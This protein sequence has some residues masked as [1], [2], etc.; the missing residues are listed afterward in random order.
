LDASYI[1]HGHL[2]TFLYVY[3]RYVT[4]VIY[5]YQQTSKPICMANF[6]LEKMIVACLV[7]KSQKPGYYPEP[8]L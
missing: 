6:F 2:C 3:V 8:F 5:T 1:I 7:N 4:K